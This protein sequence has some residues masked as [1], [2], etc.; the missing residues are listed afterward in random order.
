MTSSGVRTTLLT[1]GLVLGAALAT[2]ENKQ[3]KGEITDEMCGAEHMMEGMSPK[4]CA[5]EC[6]R[7]GSKYAL[8]VPADKKLYG[9]DRQDEAKKF[10][11]ETVVVRGELSDDG[12]TIRVASIRKAD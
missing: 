11:G 5:D 8:Y 9:L 1:M 4:E 12:K 6:V 2:A 7:M 10:S 3:W